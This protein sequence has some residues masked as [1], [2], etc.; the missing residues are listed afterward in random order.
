MTNKL[1]PLARL[2]GS[3]GSLTIAGSA[4]AV[5]GVQIAD[6]IGL[7]DLPWFQQK[8]AGITLLLLGLLILYAF[9]ERRVTSD[10]R[11]AE[12]MQALDLLVQDRL[13]TKLHLSGVRNI[14]TSRADYQKYRGQADLFDYLATSRES[15]HILAYW[16][17]HG[18]AFEGVGHKLARLVVERPQ[19][20]V[21]IAIVSP[22]GK[23]LPALAAYLGVS[24]EEVR[25]RAV[26]SRDELI[27]AKMTLNV[28]QQ[29]RFIIKLYESLPVAS[30]IMLDVASEE[31]RIQV[32]YKVYQA[33]RQESFGLEIRR[34]GTGLYHR[35]AEATL[36][37][38]ND[39]EEV[40]PT[41]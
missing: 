3:I 39:A 27:A 13:A 5:V 40:V 31:G 12:A 20:S 38:I 6:L 34:N 30:I 2:L 15:V 19:F 41:P 24:T 36:K 29:H 4:L 23:I 18:I 26:H 35:F 9:I 17:A 25:S 28:E 14:Y 22:K 8:L 7:F 21:T 11:H 10:L 37:Q 32:D 16:L 33:P 1:H